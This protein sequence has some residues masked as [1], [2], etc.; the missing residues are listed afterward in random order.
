MQK[1]KL[2]FSPSEISTYRTNEE[3][4]SALCQFFYDRNITEKIEV[5]CY[6]FTS[7]GGYLLSIIIRQ[8]EEL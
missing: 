7:L 1:N 2:W 6:S 8:K 3:I 5:G 4:G